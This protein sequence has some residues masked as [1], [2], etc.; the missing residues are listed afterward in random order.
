MTTFASRTLAGLDDA[1]GTDL[2]GCV[3]ISDVVIGKFSGNPVAAGM[4]SGN[5]PIPPGATITSAV[6]TFTSLF[7]QSSSNVVELDIMLQ[8]ADDPPDWT[9]CDAWARA[10]AA[11]AAGATLTN[12][13]VDG[14][15]WCNQCLADSPD[16][17]AGIQQIIDRPGWASGQAMMALFADDGDSVNSFTAESFERDPAD[18]PL[19]TIDYTEIPPEPQR[20]T[21]RGRRDSKIGIRGRRDSK[22]GIRGR[23]DAD[24]TIKGR[25]DTALSVRGRNDTKFSIRG[26][27]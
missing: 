3:A 25:D 21:I 9:V 8:Q 26:R 24:V 10:V 18:A 11:I 7:P 4:R 19:L 15:E 13:V 6:M 23:D 2:G 14:N 27:G 5:V 17:A 16:F 12:W 20:I 22:I 1:W